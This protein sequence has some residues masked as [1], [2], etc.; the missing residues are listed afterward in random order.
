MCSFNVIIKE[1]DSRFFFFFFLNFGTILARKCST[2]QVH[3]F[4]K[5]RLSSFPPVLSK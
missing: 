3:V 2:I 4:K 1:M 5:F